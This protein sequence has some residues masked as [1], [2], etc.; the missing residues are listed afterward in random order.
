MADEMHK[1]SRKRLSD[2]IYGI[3]KEMIADHRFA[4]GAR[5]NIEQIAKEVGASRTPV[6]EAVHRLMQE[7]LLVNF[8]NRGVFMASLTPAMA[9]ELYTVRE[10]LEGLAARLAVR[11]ISDQAIAD[12]ERCFNEQHEVVQK[13][14]LVGYSKLD[15]TFHSLVYISCG[16]LILQEMLDTI[17]NKMRPVTLHITPILSNLYEDHRKIL[18]AFKARDA[19]M[20]EEAFKSHNRHMIEQINRHLEENTWKEVSNAPADNTSG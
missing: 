16:N 17:K 13:A 10:A 14:D 18:E 3:I 15:F 5:I 6:W 19:E 20:A 9:L 4:P 1:V 11:N 8:P 7:G 2:Q 12:M